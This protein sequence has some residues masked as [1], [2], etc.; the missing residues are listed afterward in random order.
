MP[1]LVMIFQQQNT[2]ASLSLKYLDLIEKYGSRYEQA[3]IALRP[4]V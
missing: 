4:V 1:Q 3:A 2:H